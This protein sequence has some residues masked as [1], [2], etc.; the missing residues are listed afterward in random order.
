MLDEDGLIGKGFSKYL[1]R[2]NSKLAFVFTKL[3]T[4]VNGVQMTCC[5]KDHGSDDQ[6][7]LE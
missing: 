2:L 4:D 6:I 3:A 5:F 7:Y 1:C